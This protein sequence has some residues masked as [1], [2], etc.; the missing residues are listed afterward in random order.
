L[1]YFSRTETTISVPYF[2][3]FPEPLRTLS[4]SLLLVAT[5]QAQTF[6]DSTKAPVPLKTEATLPMV[7]I[8][9]SQ[10]QYD[11]RRFDTAAKIVVTQE[12]IVK[13]GD[14]TLADVLKRQPGIT[15]NSDGG[16]RM[17]GLG[18]GYTQ[19]LLNGEA[20]PPGFTLDSLSPNLIERIEIM[21]AAS[22]EF[23]TQSIAGTI[24]IVLKTK[25]IA[26]QREMKVTLEDS[27]ASV[28]FQLSDKLG[29]WSYTLG[30][31]LRRG[32]SNG[33]SS[34]IE[35]STDPRGEQN[36]LRYADSR[37]DMR[38]TSL[39]LT[40]RINWTFLDGDTL[41]WQ[42]FLSLSH[43]LSTDSTDW[44]TLLG[45]LPPYPIDRTQ[46]RNIADRIR[47]DLNWVHK[48]EGGGKL[49]AKLGLNASQR[50][51]DRREQGYDDA[52]HQTLDN[53]TLSS[54]HDQGATMAGKYSMPIAEE[55]TLATG[56]DGGH[57][58]RTETRVENDRPLSGNVPINSEQNYRA[59]LNR[60][61]LF[62][63]DEWS[64]TPKWSASMG[65]RWEM[66]DTTSQGNDFDVFHN[67]SIVFSPL[68]Q[69]LWK[70]PNSQ[71]DQIRLA[72]TR[73]Y[74]A[75][76]ITSLIPRGYTSVNN[77]SINPDSQGNP[78]LKPELATGVDL[79]YEHF[80]G[81]GAMM[82]ASVYRRQID[83]VTLYVVS[84][85]G[86][87]W[88]SMPINDGRAQT[89]G[90]ELE[91]KFPLQLLD[92]SAPA[93]DL[94]G[95]LTRNFSNVEQVPG[96]NN[97]LANQ[98]PLS[99]NFGLDFTVNPIL[100]LG[101]N[102]TSESGGLVSNSAVSSTLSSNRKGMDVFALWKFDAK[103]QLR[104]SVANILARPNTSVE[105]YVD[106]SGNLRSTSTFPASAVVRATL[107]VKI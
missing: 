29:H 35:D 3:D 92:K 25:V 16:I 104:L 71:N 79:A 93:I 46:A 13:F 8:S 67:R 58:Q 28:N 103:C 97:R 52:N 9:A 65:F 14:V 60:L 84:L 69:T 23:S 73:T 42:T 45:P 70:L 38:Y 1:K 2:L 48:F 49:D 61:A 32:L 55:H 33:P 27:S 59:T 20:T 96:P 15:V 54:A 64:I 19:I 98:T 40:P 66:L 31:S 4:L 85:L 99:I 44:T 57:S 18:S 83:D 102:F 88:I 107:E 36:L 12:E 80:F 106:A 89:H 37:W 72:L 22:A 11:A 68:F 21:R 62:A 63:Q 6:A 91:A 53:V 43:V 90:I 81:D 41:T 30:G 24:N 50:D 95:N 75:P 47:T 26:A 101:G 17:R 51:A 94:H 10:D 76:S 105:Q 82:S 56:W 87:R 86:E 78:G 39:T 77:S 5:A 100:S 74:K 34:Q 7:E